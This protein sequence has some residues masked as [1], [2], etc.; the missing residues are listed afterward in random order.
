[1]KTVFIIRNIRHQNGEV[2]YNHTTLSQQTK[3]DLSCNK[4]I[5]LKEK[6][7]IERNSK[8]LQA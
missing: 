6:N 5:K 4:K 7:K 3:G 1:M 8:T 2:L